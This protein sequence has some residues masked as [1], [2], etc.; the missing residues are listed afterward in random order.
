MV[1]SIGVIG[2]G[3]IGHGI[4]SN[5]RKKL[6]RDTAFHM[7]DVNKAVCDR[8]VQEYTQYGSVNICRSVKD[9]ASQ[10]EIVIS[11][12]PST[13]IVRDVYLKG[14][15]VLAATPSPNRLL[16]ECSTI[17]IDDT[18]EIGNKIMQ[19]GLGTFVDA[20]V[21]GGAWD[22]REGQLAF[23]VGHPTSVD[24]TG[25]Q[26]HS[27]LSLV[28]VPSKIRFCGKLGMGQV[29]KIAHNYVCI[30]KLLTATEGM[31]LGIRY[32]I[33]KK[34]L[35]Q[36]MTDGAANSWVMG[37]EQPVLGI[38]DDAPSSRNFERAFAVRLGLKD[39]GIAM[40]AAEKVGLEP[41]VGNVAFEAFRRV[42]EDERT[43][44][45][46]HSSIW[47]HVTGMLDE[48]FKEHKAKL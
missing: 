19:A 15:G 26:I 10:S 7:F 46:D 17:D 32:G 25:H 22:A 42:D 41:S 28:G 47:L 20:T 11:S 27:I 31:A 16:I 30:V 36:C 1:Q 18:I 43:R 45:L 23:M 34:V 3:V 21:S 5:L 4:A 48:W 13:K 37:L 2:L 39:L 14:D 6:P 40:R 38:V 33:D 44:D 8:F 12:L 35:W 24:K 29:A 9:L